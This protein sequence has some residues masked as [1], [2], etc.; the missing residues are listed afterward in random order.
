MSDNGTDPIQISFLASDKDAIAA[1]DRMVAQL[2]S[3]KPASKG[4]ADALDGLTAST[5]KAS[6]GAETLTESTQTATDSIVKLS[7]A[8][9]RAEEAG[10]K[11]DAMARTIKVSGVFD[12]V[13]ES[14]VGAE[15]EIKKT[16]ET[17]RQSFSRTGGLATD[18]AKFF[19]EAAFR[20]KRLLKRHLK[21]RLRQ[22]LL[23]TRLSPVYRSR[24][25]ASGLRCRVSGQ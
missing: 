19:E 21:L 20:Q 16:G 12:G 3:L 23:P 5:E 22:R 11:F 10:R 4:A 24:S 25:K 6:D 1:I 8:E 14:A 2:E 7:D 18:P 9:R 13:A 15:K 17:L